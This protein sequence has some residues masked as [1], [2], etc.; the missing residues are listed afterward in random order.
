MTYFVQKFRIS[1]RGS[2]QQMLKT[3]AFWIKKAL[4]SSH[5]ASAKDVFGSIVFSSSQEAREEIIGLYLKF[6]EDFKA[7]LDTED[8]Q[9]KT[10]SNI[11]PLVLNFQLFSP[12]EEIDTDS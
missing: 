11:S 4:E 9:K 7:I 12:G 1:D 2:S 5:Q 10:S 8:K 3:R 6:F